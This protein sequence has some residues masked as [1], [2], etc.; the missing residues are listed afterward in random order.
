VSSRVYRPF[1]PQNFVRRVAV[2]ATLTR[3]AALGTLSQGERVET[4]RAR[5][6]V[7]R[8]GQDFPLSF[9]DRSRGEGFFVAPDR[10]GCGARI[11][12]LMTIPGAVR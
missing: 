5:C 4:E 1:I 6:F 12:M 7:F 10:I 9:R 8:S 2:E 3:L 11:N